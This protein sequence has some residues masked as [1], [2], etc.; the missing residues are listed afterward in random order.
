MPNFDFLDA[1]FAIT[2]VRSDDTT[3]CPDEVDLGLSNSLVIPPVERPA[4]FLRDA[5]AN[6]AAKDRIRFAHGT[7]TLAFSFK[8]GIIVAVDSR[9]SMGQYI[10]SGTVKKI[11]EINP[12]L[13]GTMAGGAA[14]CSFWE[15]D[16]GRRCKLYG[17]FQKIASAGMG[18]RLRTTCVRSDFVLVFSL[19]IVAQDRTPKQGAHFGRRS[20]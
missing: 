15:R 3:V 4:S 19:R 13:L 20:I 17:T 8:G 6:S 16:L 14:D 11:I 1:D 2:G 10:G 5:F 18:L 7:T 9:A 12:Y